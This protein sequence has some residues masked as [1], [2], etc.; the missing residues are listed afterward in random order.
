MKFL[1]IGL[2]RVYQLCIRPFIGQVCR[3]S[4]T[5]SQYACEALQK[6]GVFRGVW[7]TAKRLLKCHP[8]HPGGVDEP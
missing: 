8:W 7:L 1:F 3:F 5:C 4:P 2:I 6:H